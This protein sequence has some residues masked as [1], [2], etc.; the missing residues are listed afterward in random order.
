MNKRYS[1]ILMILSASLLPAFVFAQQYDVKLG[2]KIIRLREIKNNSALSLPGDTSIIKELSIQGLS[3]YIKISNKDSSMTYAV[4]ETNTNSLREKFKRVVSVHNT[5]SAVDVETAAIFEYQNSLNILTEQFVI[6]FRDDVSR[7][8]IDDY[9]TNNNI[10]L[11]SDS[12]LFKNLFLIRFKNLSARQALINLPKNHPLIAFIEPNFLQVT[13]NRPSA[14]HEVSTPELGYT[15]PDV[16]QEPN[17]LYLNKQWYLKNIGAPVGIADADVRCFPGWKISRGSEKVLIAILDE[18]VDVN[19]P[20]LR[21]K[22]YATYDA[23]EDDE[24][25]Q[26]QATAGHGTACAGI[27]AAMTNNE[28]GIAG[29][30]WNTKIMAVRIASVN[31]EKQWETTPYIIASGIKKA[32]DKGARILSC[33]WGGGL[34][35]SVVDLSI[36]YGIGQECVFV[37]AAG[38]NNASVSY[39]GNLSTTKKIITVS[40]TNEWDQSKAPDSKDKEEWWGTNYGREITISA[41]GVHM[42]TTDITG[43]RRGYDKSSDYIFNFNGTSSATPLVAGSVALMLAVNPK[44]TLSEIIAVVKNNCDDL[45]KSGRDDRFGYG[46]LNVEKLLLAAGRI[47]K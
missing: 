42:A 39:P 26:P 25:Q 17:D 24:D 46:R 41:P 9:F 37:F 3:Q 5:N 28:K 21:E 4:F 38:N 40:A 44:L 7:R 20:D 43:H 33:S 2:G 13:E 29:V 27:A 6:R 15:P 34:P 1:T 36:D 45:G 14:P 23:V 12:E 8:E 30:G 32:V 35:S 19:H 22:I 18:G 16:S 10:E 11:E 47:Q 31:M